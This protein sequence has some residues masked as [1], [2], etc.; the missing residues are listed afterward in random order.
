MP[1]FCSGGRGGL[2]GNGWGISA[3]VDGGFLYRRQEINFREK[4]PGIR[5]KRKISWVL[6]LKGHIWY[7][8]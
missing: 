5:R 7:S 2:G 6:T 3:A 1:A 8:I 4:F